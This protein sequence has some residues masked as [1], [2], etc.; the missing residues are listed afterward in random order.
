GPE[1]DGVPQR[2]SV[3]ECTDDWVLKGYR[4][5][6]SSPLPNQAL[7][8]DLCKPEANRWKNIQDS[9]LPF[10]LVAR[11]ETDALYLE[12]REFDRRLSV[13]MVA[14]RGA[15]SGVGARAAAISATHLLVQKAALALD[16]ALDEF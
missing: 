3:E 15:M 13:D 10:G 2:F 9:D 1:V 12:L 8:L 6:R 7:D 4:F 11:K 5:V 16:V 14:K